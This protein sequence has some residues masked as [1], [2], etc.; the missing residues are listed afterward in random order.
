MK[1]GRGFILIR[2]A[3]ADYPTMKFDYKEIQGGY[4]VEFSYDEQKKDED[5]HYELE[6]ELENELSI[7]EKKYFKVDVRKSQN[8]TT[9]T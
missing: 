1:H 9:R 7:K 3:I 8:L 6:N 5:T 2:K 4:L